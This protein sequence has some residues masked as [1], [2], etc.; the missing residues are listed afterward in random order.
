MLD[1]VAAN[2][3]VAAR[4]D[5]PLHLGVTEAGADARRD[6]KVGNRH[7]RAGLCDGIG[8]TIRVS[9]YSGPTRCLGKRAG[10][11]ILAALGLHTSGVEVIFLPDLRA[12]GYRYNWHRRAA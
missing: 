3:I 11:E 4:C 9:L 7:R 1:T 8:D 6:D 2:R 12:H 5:Y 10:A